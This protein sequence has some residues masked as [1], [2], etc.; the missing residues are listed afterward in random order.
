[1]AHLACDDA[2]LLNRHQVAFGPTADALTP[3]RLA[4]AY[5][6]NALALVGDG[7]LV[8]GR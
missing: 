8:L 4:E 6:P 1:V 5:G 7:T 3:A 2:C